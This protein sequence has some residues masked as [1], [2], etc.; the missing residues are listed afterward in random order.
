MLGGGVEV[1][2]ARVVLVGRRKSDRIFDVAVENQAL[3]LQVVQLER[4]LIRFR[5]EKTLF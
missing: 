1:V 4:L 5:E 2:G 3:V